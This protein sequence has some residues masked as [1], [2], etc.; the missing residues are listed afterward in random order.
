MGGVQLDYRTRWANLALRIDQSA[1]GEVSYSA[2]RLAL[3]VSEFIAVRALAIP[4][5]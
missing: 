3:R 4:S 1:F 2:G 5:I